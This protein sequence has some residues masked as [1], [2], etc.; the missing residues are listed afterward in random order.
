[1][2]PTDYLKIGLITGLFIVGV[3]IGYR[4]EHTRFVA[5]KEKTEAVAKTQEA[6]VESITKQQ[7]LVTKGIKDE[8]DAKLIAVRNYYKSTSM[9]N[10]SSSSE[11][12]GRNTY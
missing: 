8:Y 1:M 11:V 7:D 2:N 10:N 4:F 9:W 6:K 12:S 3:A 5:F